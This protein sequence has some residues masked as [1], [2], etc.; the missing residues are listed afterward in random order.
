MFKFNPTTGK[1]DLVTKTQSLVDYFY[2]PGISGGQTAIGGTGV[3]DILQLQGTSGNG[4]LTSPAI[5]AKVGN[6]GATTALTVLNNGNVGIGT[7][8]PLAKLTTYGQGDNFI[9]QSGSDG[10][11]AR[12]SLVFQGGATNIEARIQSGNY[13]GYNGGL[14]FQVSPV[15][16]SAGTTTVSALFI[17]AGGNVGIGTTSP[18]VKLHVV[19][20]SAL[21][22]TSGITQTGAAARFGAGPYAPTLTSVV[23]VGSYNLS[24][25]GWIQA[26]DRLNL[27][28]E[29]ALL[30]NPNGGNVGIGTTNPDK[31]LTLNQKEDANGIKIYGYDDKSSVSGEMYIDSNGFLTYRGA[32]GVVFGHFGDSTSKIYFNRPSYFQ[33]GD[34]NLLTGINLKLKDGNLTLESGN[35]G[36]GTTAPGAPLQI[37]NGTA[38]GTILY[39]GL[40]LSGGWSSTAVRQQNLITFKA[41]DNVSAD[42]FSDT[43]GETV[44]NWHLGLVSDGSYNSNSRF[45]IINQGNERLTVANSGNVGIGITTPTAKLDVNSDILRLRT[46]KTPAT[47]GSAG[48]AGDICWDAN[49]IYVCTATNTWV[50]SALTTW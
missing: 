31:L 6:N 25:A 8:N 34:V 42:P 32:V 12:H 43:S 47:A 14:D 46:A 20:G 48:N 2:K 15:Q 23:D 22:A 33:V 49:Y 4:T 30:L 18:D 3:T 40:I 38:N 50:R 9:L 10:T 5:Q 11:G 45:S 27:A 39:R 36:I 19:G 1:L 29:Y 44:K 24:G 26:T 35:V 41:T 7:T 16:A 17:K 21:P 13:N 28:T 37:G